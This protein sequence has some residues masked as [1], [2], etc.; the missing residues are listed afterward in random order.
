MDWLD[1]LL[2]A[3]LIFGLRMCDVTLGTVKM[4]IALQGR[5]YVAAAIGFVEVTIFVIAIGKVVGQL[6]NIVN[7]LAYSGGFACGT[8]LGIT[9]E[10][11]LALGNRVVKVIT[12]RPN[13]VLV[14]EL[15]RLLFGVTR[16]VGEGRDG[17]V[18]ILFSVVRRKDLERFVAVVNK[19]APK[20]FVAVEEAREIWRGYMPI[21][22]S[23]VK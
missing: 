6:D 12:H 23:K 21:Y 22:N 10:S 5:R 4:M 3:L 19:F 16:I 7:V 11:K 1:T 9:V 2:G 18:Y 14:S 13:D 8:M 15:R 17:K 20:A